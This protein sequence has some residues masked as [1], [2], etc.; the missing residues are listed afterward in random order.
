MEHHS[1]IVER[2]A[3]L[4]AGTRHA[5]LFAGGKCDDISETRG[6]PI[7]EHCVLC[8]LRPGFRRL[9]LVSIAHRKRVDALL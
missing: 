5:H 7:H 6:G 9:V 3:D 1:I 4:D 2:D 8:G